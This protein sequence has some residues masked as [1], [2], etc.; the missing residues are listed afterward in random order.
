MSRVPFIDK[1]YNAISDP[2][3]LS[4]VSWHAE[5]GFV[6]SDMEKFEQQTLSKYNISKNM[7]SFKIQLSKFKIILID[8]TH[9]KQE[10][11]LLQ[12]GRIDL[13]RELV[14]RFHVKRVRT[15]KIQTNADCP[16]CARLQKELDTERLSNQRRALEISTLQSSLESYTHRQNL[17]TT[18]LINPRPHLPPTK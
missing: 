18:H 1:L 10:D 5:G 13:A 12:A 16:N 3:N 9:Y 6:I 14:E 8:T 7:H 11:N 17:P 4:I 2:F 15:E